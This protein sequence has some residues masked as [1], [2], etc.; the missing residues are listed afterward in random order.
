MTCTLSYII[1]NVN[2]SEI[3]YKTFTL[4]YNSGID[5]FHILLY[6]NNFEKRGQIRFLSKQLKIKKIFFFSMWGEHSDKK[7]QESQNQIGLRVALA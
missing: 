7:D 3:F 1:S 4:F 2:L 6:R 5:Y